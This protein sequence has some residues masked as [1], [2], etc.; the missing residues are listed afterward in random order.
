[1]GADVVNDIQVPPGTVDLR[2]RSVLR[3]EIHV[4]DIDGVGPKEVQIWATPPA[5]IPEGHAPDPLRL[6]VGDRANQRVQIWLFLLDHVDKPL[7]G[8]PWVAHYKPVATLNKDPMLGHLPAFQFKM[9]L[10]TEGAK[11]LIVM[12]GATG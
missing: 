8:G 7:D 10:V 9:Q 4:F 6:Q 11:Q 1:M 3:L 2:P 12:P 5:L